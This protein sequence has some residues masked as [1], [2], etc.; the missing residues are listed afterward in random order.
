MIPTELEPWFTR[1]FLL[2]NI[3]CQFSNRGVRSTFM[4][5]SYYFTHQIRNSLHYNMNLQD[6]WGKLVGFF[7]IFWALLIWPPSFFSSNAKIASYHSSKV[8]DWC[9]LPELPAVASDGLE[10]SWMLLKKKAVETQV[11]RLSAA[12]N[13]AAIS[14]DDNEDVDNDPRWAKFEELEAVLEKYFPLV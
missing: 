11:K 7:C 1:Q 13:I 4:I 8:G 3:T 5:L 10:P 14:Y 9:P 6:H 12:V 2:V